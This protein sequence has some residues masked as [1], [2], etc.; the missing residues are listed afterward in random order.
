MEE[1]DLDVLKQIQERL[2]KI[3]EIYP[4]EQKFLNGVIR[5]YK[6]KKVVEMGVSAGGSAALILNAIKDIPNAKLYSIDRYTNWCGNHSKLTGWSVKEKYPELMN[7]WTLYTGKTT[8]EFMET[9]GDNIDL[10]YIDTVHISPG[11]MLNWLDVLPFLKEEAI[12]VFHDIFLMY[13]KDIPISAK[14]NF[15]N[16]QL[17]CY[18]RGTIILPSYG[19]QTFN[20]N[21]GAIK[22]EKNQKRYYKQYFLALGNNW[23]YFLEEKDVIALREHY[24]K[25]YGEKLVKIYDDAVEK[26]RIRL[27]KNVI[28]VIN[29]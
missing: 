4:D 3:I 22:L 27:N 28:K 7:K 17:L 13:H 6:P 26:N 9:I 10:V 1:F 25:Y 29:F 24:K 16:N 5:K 23:D 15:S 21:I 18:I 19:N 20:R 2:E 14:N 8:A 12:V 11:E